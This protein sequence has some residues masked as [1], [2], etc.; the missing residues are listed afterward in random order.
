VFRFYRI[1]FTLAAAGRD[2]VYFPPGKAANVLRGA[3]GSTLRQISCDPAVCDSARTCGRRNSCAYARIFEPVLDTGP[4]GLHDPPRPFVLRA[5]ALDGQTVRPGQPFHF[6][7]HLFLAEEPPFT[8]LVKALAQLADSGLGPARGRVVLTAA[9]LLDLSGVPQ[10]RILDNGRFV[11]NELPSPLVLDLSADPESKPELL[12]IDFLTPTEIKQG[13]RVLDRPLFP[14]LLSRIRD[15]LGSLSAL[16]GGGPLA[17]DW[18]GLSDRAELVTLHSWE[19][20]E[21][22]RVDRFSTKTLQTHPLGGFTGRAAYAGPFDEFLPLL[23]A[24]EF[25]GVGR[26]TVWGKGHIRVLSP[27]R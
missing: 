12:Q 19:E 14:A 27:Q 17:L 6:D 23:H 24:A 3:L 26:Q 5:S 13:G 25:T 15:R 2:T 16:Y 18:K 22:A 21:R 10:S 1:R 20:G 8:D 4:S 9:D 11:A 7:L